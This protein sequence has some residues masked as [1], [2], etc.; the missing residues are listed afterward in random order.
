[1]IDSVVFQMYRGQYH[2]ERNNKFDSLRRKT[3]R[4][5]SVDSASCEKYFREQ[6][7]KG[8]YCPIVSNPKNKRGYKDPQETIEIQV[9]LPKLVYGTNVYEIEENDLDLIF[10]NLKNCLRGF[11]VIVSVSS[12]R[13]AIIKR[14]DFSKNIELPD[15]LGKANQVIYTLSKFDYKTRS[16]FNFNQYQ[17]NKGI[18][19]KFYNSTQGFCIYD[20]YAEIVNN[21]YTEKEK[22]IKKKIEQNELF[23]NLTKLELSFQRKDSFESFLRKRINKNRDFTLT[24]MLNRELS[25]NILIES[26]DRV[27]SNLVMGLISLSEMEDNK[28]W[29]IMEKRELSIKKQE[30]LYYWTRMATKNGITGTFNHLKTQYKGSSFSRNKK[31]INSILEELKEEIIG[32][33]PNLISFLRSQIDEFKL[34]KPQRKLN[35]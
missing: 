33:M 29:A 16:E 24:D 32:N 27:F 18:W 2:I 3:G 26:F 31:E 28:I 10:D 13:E 9:S 22:D 34:I 12:L 20:K 23:R 35:L 25:R 14:A 5:F 4:G 8:V 19:I 15:Y 7:A 21:G 1:M 17:G 30:K 6:K 11:G